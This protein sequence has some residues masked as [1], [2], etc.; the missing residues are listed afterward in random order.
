M[1]FTTDLD[2]SSIRALGDFAR[3]ARAEGVEV[4]LGDAHHRVRT[5]LQRE[6]LSPLLGDLTRAYSI[7]ELVDGL[8]YDI[9]PPTQ[10]RLQSR[11]P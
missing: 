4:L 6:K 9:P 3:R 7:A 1:A 11:G 10:A 5:L 2:L 8:Q